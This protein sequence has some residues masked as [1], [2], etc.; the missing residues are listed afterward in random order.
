MRAKAIASLACEGT[1]SSS[2]VRSRAGAHRAASRDISSGLRVPPPEAI[3]S[4]TSCARTA[5]PTVTAVS[6]TRVATR[7]SS[8]TVRWPRCARTWSR[9][10]SSL[11]V[12]FGG[13]AA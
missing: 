8:A 1:P 3:T 10:K 7:S 12:D 9:W 6:S 5:S 11:P 2:I 4:S 13:G